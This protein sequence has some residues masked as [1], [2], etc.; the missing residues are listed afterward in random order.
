MVPTF[1][2]IP[3][4]YLFAAIRSVESMNLLGVLSANSTATGN[5]SQVFNASSDA[6]PPNCTDICESVVQTSN[7]CATFSCLC[8]SN[9]ETNITNCV[10]CIISV[11]PTEAVIDQ[12]QGIIDRASIPPFIHPLRLCTSPSPSLIFHSVRRYSDSGF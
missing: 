11:K 12:G 2:V 3:V 9:R 6:F 4:L 10:N 1:I 7:T 5:A 8:S